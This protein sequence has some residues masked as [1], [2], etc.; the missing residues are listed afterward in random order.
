[1]IARKVV[2][3]KSLPDGWVVATTVQLDGHRFTLEPDTELT[4]RFANGRKVRCRF[5]RMVSVR[6]DDAN[7][8]LAPWL[9]V[10]DGK[11]VRS[12][13]PTQVVT[14]HRTHKVPKRG[15]S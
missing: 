13:Q 3:V 9:D 11:A 1:V 5:R 12:V 2:P 14:V 7:L 6:P 15:T 8:M 10:F 4:V